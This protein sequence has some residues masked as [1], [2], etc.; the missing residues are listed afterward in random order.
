MERFIA[1]VEEIKAEVNA[2]VATCYEE[3]LEAARLL[4]KELDAKPDDKKF[5]KENMPLL[6]VPMSVKE[7][8]GVKGKRSWCKIITE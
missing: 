1:R 8:F 6:G 3:A 7:A 5:S 2:V 4:D